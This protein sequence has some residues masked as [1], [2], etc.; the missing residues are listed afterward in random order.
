VTALP[1]TLGRIRG[2]LHP[3]ERAPGDAC[4]N[5]A[6]LEGLLPS[7]PPVA[8]A[9]LVGLV[10]R[11][12]G[13]RVLLTRRNDG[14]RHHA[15]QVSFPGGRI[16]PSDADPADAAIRETGEEI[17]IGPASITPLG[18]LDPIATVT[19]FRVLPLVA[20]IDV[21][22]VAVRDAREVDA[23]FE[24]AFETLMAPANLRAIQIDWDGRQR[25]V[26][27]YVDDVHP[28]Q[29]I[30]GVSASI[31]LNLRQRLEASP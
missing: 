18:Y 20:A 10:P 5:L 26:L 11:V 30:W 7:A 4:W 2:A 19:G 27:Q 24:V 16:E 21:G 12:D 17:G 14:L 29:R 1:P 31:L 6:E 23:V 25:R 22:Y 13:L 9:V 3:L 8:A 15:G 28:G